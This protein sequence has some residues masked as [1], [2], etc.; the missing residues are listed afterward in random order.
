MPNCTADGLTLSGLGR[1]VVE[2][3]FDGGAVLL[4]EV[5]RR[6]GLLDRVSRSLF[7]GRD[8]R[9]IDHSLPALL[10]QRVFGVALGHCDLNDHGALRADPAFQTAVSRSEPLASASTLCRLEQAADTGFA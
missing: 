2:A 5:E 7:D 8:R 10:R 4:R 3:T 6:T 9:Y 1:R